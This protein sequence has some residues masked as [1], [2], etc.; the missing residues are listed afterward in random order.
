MTA[1]S[2]T[3]CGGAASSASHP[4]SAR[5]PGAER[6]SPAEQGKG[7]LGPAHS[8]H[9]GDLRFV[10]VRGIGCDQVE[11]PGDLRQKVRKEEW[12][13]IGQQPLR[14]DREDLTRVRR[15]IGGAHLEPR[16]GSLEGDADAARARAGVVHAQQ[17]GLRA[18]N[19]QS[20]LDQSLGVGPGNKHALVDVELQ[21]VK[22]LAPADVGDRR[23]FRALV[24]KRA[25]ALLGARLHGIGQTGE[26]PLFRDVRGKGKQDE[27]VEHRGVDLRQQQSGG[28][29]P[30]QGPEGHAL[31]EDR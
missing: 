5:L 12:E 24:Q 29:L 14:V 3:S 31:S 4:R 30:E 16:L 7:G 27:R 1:V 8:S 17:A 13:R 10:E 22:L 15:D 18:Q 6:I 28:A 21:A 2:R 25:I 23:S 11:L 26:E 19:V 9:V 20:A